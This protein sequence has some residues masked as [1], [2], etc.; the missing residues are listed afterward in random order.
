[1]DGGLMADKDLLEEA[2]ERFKDSLD[3]ESDNRANLLDDVRFVRLGEQWPEEILR[4]R[5][6]DKRPCLTINKLPAFV[7]QVVNDA[8]QNRPA[9]TVTGVDSQADP[10]TAEVLSG[11]IRHIERNSNADIAYDTA[12]EWAVTGGIGYFTIGTEYADE[13][14]FEQELCVK[15]VVNPCSIYGDCDSESADGSDWKYAFQIITGDREEMEKQ[16]KSKELS[17][18]E[19]GGLGDTTDDEDDLRIARYW[20]VEQERKT[21]VQL[22]NGGAI[23]D[24]QLTPDLIELLQANGVAPTD[25]SRT[26]MVPKVKFYVLSGNGVL[27][28]TEWAGR[29]IPIIPVYGEEFWVE[30]KRHWKSLVRDQKDAQ[31]MFNY[32]R[33]AST[34]MVALQPKAP[35]IGPKG[36]AKS[37]ANKWKTANIENHP[38]LEYDGDQPPQRQPMPQMPAGALQEALNANDDMKAIAGIYDAS[39]GAR[40]NETSG[41]AIMARQREGDVSTFHFIDNLTRSIRQAGRVLVDLI[42]KIYDTPRIVRI[43]GKDDEAEQVP[44]NQE[45]QTQDDTGQIILA[46]HDLRAG[47]YDVSVNAGPSYTTQRQEAADQMIE[48]IRAFPD[49]APFVGDLLAKNLDWP[50]AD[51]IAKRLEAIVPQA[52]GQGSEQEAQMQQQ[53]AQAEAAKASADVQLK[54]M[55]VQLK[56]YDV[57]IKELEVQAKTIDAQARRVQA[58]AQVLTAQRQAIQPPAQPNGGAV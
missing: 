54:Q 52:P 8:R 33:T 47:K 36:F 19:N 11:I 26:I 58:E 49:A 3:A 56:Q 48:L 42:P 14:S 44:V 9:I 12:V 55:D 43:I 31:R 57:R 45:Y 38:F 10:K 5:E 40:S 50:G 27:E 37:S 22:S 1:M 21:L 24:D 23:T 17:S 51:E 35:W 7:R 13:E 39:L 46:M 29:Y 53:A 34:E 4:Q 41:R 15:R 20:K 28:E 32:W 18:W 30:D 16:Y 25:T 6:R 2:Q